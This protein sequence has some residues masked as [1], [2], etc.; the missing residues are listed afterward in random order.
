MEQSIRGS[1]LEIRSMGMEFKSGLMVLAMKA[2]GS[3]TRPAEKES[4]GTL[5]EMYL[6]AN[7]KTTKPMATEFTFT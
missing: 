6:K 1:G 4:S 3:T 7:G 5:M 2:I